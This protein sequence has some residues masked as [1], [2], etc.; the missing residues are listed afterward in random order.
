MN[1]QVNLKILI[2]E[3]LKKSQVLILRK[4][5]ESNIEK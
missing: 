1:I 2:R 5:F 4:Q 3:E